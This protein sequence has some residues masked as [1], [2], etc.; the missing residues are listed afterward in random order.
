VEILKQVIDVDL[1]MPLMEVFMKTMQQL[2]QRMLLLLVP[3]M[4]VEQHL[5]KILEVF[6]IVR[7]TL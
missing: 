3:Q 1:L 5:L 6:Q 4:D 2:V 7:K